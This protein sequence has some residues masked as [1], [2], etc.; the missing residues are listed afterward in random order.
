MLRS[1]TSLTEQII[2][3]HPDAFGAGELPYW[4]ALPSV[5]LHRG[6][7]GDID[8]AF[9]GRIA[10]EYEQVLQHYSANASRVVDKMPGNYCWLGLIA[11]VFPHAR[12]I[13][14]QRDP[15]DTCLSIYFQNFNSRSAYGTD[16]EDLAFYYRE[17]VRLMHHWRSVLPPERFL[18]VP[19]EALTADQEG[20][21]RRIIG[22]LG[23]EWNERC[24]E[25][26]KTERKVGTAS[27][28]QVRQKIYQ[29]SKARW[30][31]YEKHLGP[32][33]GLLEAVGSSSSHEGAT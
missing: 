14:T 18:E 23:L 22:F 16:L 8:S 2:A 29:T 13:H 25:F 15:I 28:W 5:D 6:I 11:T 12:I 7:T 20:W 17:Y 27:N 4:G 19:Y 31:H 30:R 33:L 24:L 32:L 9:I 21:S 10:A 3:S 26:H 1:G